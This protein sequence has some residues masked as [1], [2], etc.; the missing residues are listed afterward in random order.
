MEEGILDKHVSKTSAL[1]S[2]TNYLLGKIFEDQS[3]VLIVLGILT[4]SS[5][6]GTQ[7]SDMFNK[8]ICAEEQET[9]GLGRPRTALWMEWAGCKVGVDQWWKL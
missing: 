2:V 3:C 1:V 9:S 8:Q 5:G 6:A 4:G 7:H